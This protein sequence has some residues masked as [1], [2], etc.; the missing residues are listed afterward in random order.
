[1]RRVFG[2]QSNIGISADSGKGSA[3]CIRK[4]FAVGWV[5]VVLPAFVGRSGFSERASWIQLATEEWK[6]EK[7]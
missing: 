1:M 5:G 3:F 6:R 7:A 4:A 2:L